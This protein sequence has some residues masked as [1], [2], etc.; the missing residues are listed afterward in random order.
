LD[1]MAYGGRR[2]VQAEREGFSQKSRIMGH[3]QQWMQGQFGVAGASQTVA[4]R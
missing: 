4:V 3:L 2:A 1:I